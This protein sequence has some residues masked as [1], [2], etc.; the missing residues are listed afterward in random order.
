[1]FGKL[2]WDAIPLDE[3]IPLMTSAVVI[4]GVIGVGFWVWRKGWWPHFWQEYITSTDHKK[5]GVMYIVLAL[6]M[7]VRGFADAIMMRAQQAMAIGTSQGYL[8]P[9]H[10]D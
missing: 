9:E 3:P 10:Y 6:L 1:M 7:L 4:L 5:I 2:T 8:P